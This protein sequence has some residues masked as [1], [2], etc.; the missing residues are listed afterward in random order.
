[1][2]F[3]ATALL[4]LTLILITT[5]AVLWRQYRA[6]QNKPTMQDSDN[7][8]QLL[9]EYAPDAYYLSDL[10][11]TFIDG[12]QKAE[13]LV[14]YQREELIGKNFLR[15]NLLPA[16]YIPKAVQALAKNVGGLATGPDEFVLKHKD[17]RQVTVEISTTPIKFKGQTLVLGIARDVTERQQIEQE[18]ALENKMLEA[19]NQLSKDVL[20]T[21]D[22]AEILQVALQTAVKFLDVTSGY[23]SDWDEAQNTITTIAEY[24]TPYANEMERVSDM[25][26]G[27][28]LDEEFGVTSEW[29]LPPYDR[30]V[31]HWDDPNATPQ[32]REHIINFGA[33]SIVEVPLR[34]KDKPIGT[35]ELWESR[36]KRIFSTHELSFALA[37]ARQVA[38]AIENARLY[39]E[40]LAAS[41]LKSALLANVSHELRTP[42]SVILIRAEML[43]AG[44]YGEMTAQQ[45]GILQQTINSAH[46]LTRLVNEL[47]VGAQLEAGQLGLQVEE[48]S[49]QNVVTSALEQMSMFAQVKELQLVQEIAPN[50]PERLWGDPERIHQILLNLIGNG[51]KFTPQGMVKVRA[52]Q[53]NERQ[54]ALQI[55]D[56]GAGIPQ[57]AQAFIFEPFRQVDDSATRQHGGSGLGL[58]IVKQLSVLMGGEVVLESQPGHGSKFTVF[59]PIMTEK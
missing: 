19:I 12:N 43:E 38:L 11:G 28:K 47:I 48:F 37:I 16:S 51:I 5:N 58:A 57:E 41:R 15:L 42:L 21:F 35:L 9:F 31:T 26:V 30:F 59:L 55:S 46:M 17:G 7:K 24:Y 44:I 36:R 18:Q 25:G 6:V 49:P 2:N 29:M 10:K 3:L 23:I 54:W 52:Y 34:A 39:E 33:K 50:L 45:K 40:T 13:N 22:L 27:Y 1:M 14:G 20:S 4:L 53:A 32:E 56:T 8:F